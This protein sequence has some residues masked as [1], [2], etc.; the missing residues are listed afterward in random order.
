MLLLEQRLIMDTYQKAWQQIVT[1]PSR[2]YEAEDFLPQKQTV[3]GE[4]VT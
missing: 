4:E 2:K 3:N 1:P